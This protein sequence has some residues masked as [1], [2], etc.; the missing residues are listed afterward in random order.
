MIYDNLKKYVNDNNM[1]YIPLKYKI[2]KDFKYYFSDYYVRT[3][4]ARHYEFPDDLKTV[5]CGLF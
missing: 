1:L 4:G 2:S 5:I 3:S